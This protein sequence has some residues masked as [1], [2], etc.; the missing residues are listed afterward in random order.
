MTKRGLN[1]LFTRPSRFVY[2]KIQNLDSTKYREGVA[3][4][5]LN[6][7]SFRTIPVAVPKR[8]EQDQFVQVLDSVE[9]KEEVHRRKHAALTAL[10]RTVLHQL[11]TAQLRVHDLDLPELETAI[12]EGK[13]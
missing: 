11:M 7:N 10:F 2:Y 3:V 8:E 1:R 6:R 5:T 9:Q 4:P 13:K 12:A